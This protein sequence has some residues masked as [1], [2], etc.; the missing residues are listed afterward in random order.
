MQPNIISANMGTVSYEGEKGNS[1]THKEKSINK[2]K[3]PLCRKLFRGIP[4]P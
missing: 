3:L 4:A 2:V 1:E